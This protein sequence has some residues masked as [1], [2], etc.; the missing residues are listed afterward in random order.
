MECIERIDDVV[1]AAPPDDP[2]AAARDLLA[3]RASCF[4][5]LD[6]G[7]L[8]SVAQPGSPIEASD[9]IA[10]AAALDGGAA[11]ETAFFRV[12][13]R[14]KPFDDVRVRR[15]LS[16]AIDR[17]KLVRH[18][19]YAET[20]AFALTPPD[21]AG[22]TADRSLAFDAGDERLMS[23]GQDGS[24]RVWDATKDV[25][26]RRVPFHDALN[27]AAFCPSPDGLRVVAA[28]TKALA[29][30][31]SVT[32]G[33]VVGETA[34]PI[35]RRPPYP[36]RYAVFLNDGLFRFRSDGTNERGLAVMRAT[37]GGAQVVVGSPK[38][39]GA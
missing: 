8:G 29:R 35:T 34:P 31:W 5:L 18:V 30:T 3:R 32:D 28:S 11:L 21:C 24:V 19:V 1:A 16:L 14:R 26:G 23:G 22:Y 15:A 17:E 12:N 4:A 7:C 38:S 37:A 6:L 25:R 20:A 27:D 9:R 39:F 10:L 33:R 36:R 2:I 13:T